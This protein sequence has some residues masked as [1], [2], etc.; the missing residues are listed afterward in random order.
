MS[1]ELRLNNLVVPV[2][3]L[4]F[5][6]GEEQV[7]IALS[8]APKGSIGFVDITAKIKNSADVMALALLVDACSR[9]ENLHNHAE[10]TLHLPYIPYAR[11]DRVMQPGEALSIKVF[12]NLVNALSFDKVIVDDPHSDVSS[13]LLNNVRVRGQ[14]TLVA[15][16]HDKLAGKDVTI[17][18]PDAGARKKAQKVS[19]R[20]RLPLVEAGKVR[21]VKT[22][23]ITGTAVFGDVEGRE[24][25]IVDDICDGGRTFIALAQALK[26][27]GAK[28]VILYV[29][30]GIF[31]FGKQVILDG[32]VD[33]I[34]AYH[35]WTENF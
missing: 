30:H 21:D 9:L 23:E 1:L 12:A 3:R 11:Q 8:H 24:C 13:A 28:R 33:E 16:F 17:I 4:T 6:G 31:S 29:T 14:E 15:E 34:Y 19:E 18:A 32:G 10:F 5:K 25:V 22:N 2:D 7:K 27:K 35:D 26:E 20:L